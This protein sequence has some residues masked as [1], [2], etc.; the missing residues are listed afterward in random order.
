MRSQPS[1]ESRL[2]GFRDPTPPSSAEPVNAPN[3]GGMAD[4]IDVMSEGLIPQRP[5]VMQ[6]AQPADL[7]DSRW[8]RMASECYT[9]STTFFDSAVRKRIEDA[10]A[11]YRSEHPAGSKYHL[12]S[13]AKRSKMFRPKT[14]AMVRKQEAAAALAFFSTGDAIS[15]GAVNSG[16]KAAVRDAKIQEAL[17][18]YR[19]SESVKFFPLIIGALQ[20]AA[21]QGFVVAKTAWQYRESTSYFSERDAN[22]ETKLITENRVVEDR[23]QIT[24]IPAENFRVDPA[25]DW[26]DP[27]NSSPYIIEIIPMYVCD[28][29]ERMRND[30]IRPS[31]RYRDYSDGELLAGMKQSWDSLRAAREGTRQDRFDAS[32]GLREYAVAWVHRNIMRVDGEDYVYDTIGTEMLLSDPVPLSEIDPRGYRPYVMGYSVIESHNPMP[33]GMVR[34]L[35][36]V[37]E[38]INETAN[39]RLDATKMAT[40]GRYFVRRGSAVDMDAL[41]RFVPAG[42]IETNNPG[43]DVKWDRAPEP[44]RGSLEEH[45][46]LQLEMDDL[47][48][49]FSGAS[50]GA[51]RQLNET[52]GGMTM[53]GEGANVLTELSVRSFSETFVEPLLRQTADLIKLWETDQTVAALVG[54]RL[55]AEAGQVFRALETPSRVM[56]NAGFGATNPI[57]RVEKMSVGL[58]TIAGMFPQMLQTADVGEITQEVFGALGYRDAARFFP[59]LAE[60]QED[61]QVAQ[62]RQQVEQLTAMV[63]GKQ[64][65]LQSKENVARIA[66]EARIAV[67]QMTVQ[68]AEKLANVRMQFDMAMK[69]L[70]LELVKLDLAIEREKN[71]LKRAE[72][73]MQR[74]ALSHTIQMAEREYMLKLQTMTVAPPPN[75]KD[76][77]IPGGSR[78]LV[79]SLRRPGSFSATSGSRARPSVSMDASVAKA[80]PSDAGVIARGDFGLI[81]GKEG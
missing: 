74:E 14:R 58:Q 43:T 53:L 30:R 18:N 54:A 9:T 29:R 21:R 36:P 72:L 51:N 20:D 12:P 63:E 44:G 2:E 56:V 37:Q 38:E 68:N 22:G 66:A 77:P 52:V 28:I 65:E 4:M 69:E 33:D 76:Q 60:G 41:T 1:S 3:T 47:I 80:D 70:E 81:P 49:N 73:Y 19:L 71:Q 25:A 62:L 35:Q 64:L 8:V 67:A 75:P 26:L 34:M 59:S 48:G 46:L 55:Q 31:L 42:V 79:S 61:P 27:I 7:S 50:V 78:E 15:I 39:L 10:H 16:D 45:N 17:L 23:P 11:L 5:T 40:M 57:K 24:L 32:N 6:S 13:F